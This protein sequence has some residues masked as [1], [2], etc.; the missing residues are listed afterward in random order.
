M[1]PGNYFQAL[2]YFHGILCKKELEEVRVLVW[3]NL[4][5]LTNIYL[6]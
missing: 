5:S 3:T 1:L 6:L 2:F 4:N